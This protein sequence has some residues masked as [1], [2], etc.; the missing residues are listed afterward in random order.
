MDLLPQIDIMLQ[1][2]EIKNKQTKKCNTI[3]PQA[4]EST[5]MHCNQYSTQTTLLLIKILYIIL[6]SYKKIKIWKNAFRPNIELSQQ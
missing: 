6:D 3:Q 4:Q 2:H 5:D 1:K